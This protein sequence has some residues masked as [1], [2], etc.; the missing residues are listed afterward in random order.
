VDESVDEGIPEK[1][2][3]FDYEEADVQRALE[4][5]LK[6]V[7]DAPWVSLPPVVIRESDSGKYQ[8]LSEVLGKGKENVS[9]EQVVL[10]LLTLQTPKK[11]SPADQFIFQ[12]RTSTPI[13]SS[14][15]DESSSL[16]AELGLTN[17]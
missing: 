9:D 14:G 10:D 5:S 1:E 13:E 3:R 17:S 4:E 6:S 11:K 16:Y 2:P 7:Y 15:H 8:P 12:R